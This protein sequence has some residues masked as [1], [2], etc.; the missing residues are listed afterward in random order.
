MVKEKKLGS[1]ERI[2]R[3]IIYITVL[4]MLGT[5]M[6]ASDIL[7]EALPNIHLVGMFVMAFTLVFRSKA[8]VS[9]YIY[10]LLNGFYMGFSPWW[11]PYTYVWTVLWGITM[12][13]PK[14]M[15]KIAACIVYPVVCSLY[16]FAFG[17]LFA[18]GQAVMFGLSFKELLAWIVAG[19][20]FDIIHGISNLF[21]GMLIFPIVELIRRLWKKL[22]ISTE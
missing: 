20:P 5:I 12:L 11:V 13:L 2:R 17:T 6:F 19:I 22:R 9:I 8:L 14:R 1:R 4:P 16:G 18:P 7:M 3:M 10:V 21:A 15:P